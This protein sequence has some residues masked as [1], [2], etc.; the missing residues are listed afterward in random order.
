MTDAGKAQFEPVV[1]GLEEVKVTSGEEDEEVLYRQRS[2][3]FRYARE[4]DPPQWK[5]R[6]LGQVKLLQ[7]K[8]NKKIRLLM[9]Q[10]KTLKIRANH[11]ITPTMELTPNV[12]S[13]RS[14]VW[15]CPADFAEG[16]LTEE[17]FA[18]RFKNSEI[19]A[20]F[21]AKFEEG[22]NINKLIH[23]QSDELE[24]A[25][26]KLTLAP[27]EEEE[28]V[29]EEAAAE[30]PKKEEEPAPVAA[31]EAAPASGFSFASSGTEGAAN[32]FG[33]GAAASGDTGFTF[34]AATDSPAAFTFGAPAGGDGAA[35][36][37]FGAAPAADAAPEK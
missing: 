16:E 26:Q 22:A 33:F 2:R 32:P 30:E 14:W 20:G 36:F 19:A 4:A 18:I 28:E 25:L 17:T 7:H 31:E 15:Q 13:D 6:G 5:E 37:S 1:N 11:F 34:G 29:V 23:E 24:A 12:G 35:A 9:R 10:E 8:E 3:L 21:K 27:P